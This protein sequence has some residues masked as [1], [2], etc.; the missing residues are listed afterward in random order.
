M[1]QDLTFSPETRA[2]FLASGVVRLPGLVP[3]AD[4]AAMADR[5]W[6]DCAER[7]GVLRERPETWRRA[8]VFQFQEL[9]RGGAF[10]PMRSA[11]LDAVLDGFFG[12]IGWVPPRAWGGPLVTFPDGDDAWTVPHRSWHLDILPGQRLDPWP[13]VVRVFALLAPL[14][15]GGAGTLCVA[16]SH[17]LAIDL[18]DS[19]RAT[20]RSARLK[21]AMKRASP[22][23]ADLCAP[24]GGPGRNRRFMEEGTD[25][26]GLQMRVVEMTGAAGDVFLMHPGVLHTASPN[27]RQAP[28][29]MLAETIAA[30]RPG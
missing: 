20:L 26:D 28:R 25:L 8:R 27:R 21:E 11:G 5:I 30:A 12:D 15:A 22:W 23:I 24:D 17:R 18:V 19:R 10:A 3:A 1:S 16:G 14:E 7:H 6:E 9:R 4:A 13:T 29:M 2:Q